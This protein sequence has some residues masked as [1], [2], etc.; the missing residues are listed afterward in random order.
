M[1]KLKVVTR[2]VFG[3]IALGLLLFLTN[4]S[5][6]VGLSYIRHSA[7]SVI[8]V[9]MPLQQQMTQV[10]TQL[11]YLGKLSLR[12]YYLDSLPELT[13]SYQ[14]FIALQQTYRTELQ[15]LTDMVNEPLAV[16]HLKRG[17]DAS[18]AYFMAVE[19][20]YELQKRQHQSAT[21]IA[22]L[23][24]HNITQAND[25]T[26]LL[27][28]IE[29]LENGD[30]DPALQKLVGQ[31]NNIDI[32]LG[33][34]LDNFEDL[35]SIDPTEDNGQFI[36]ELT[37]AFSNLEQAIVF[38]KRSAQDVDT[39]GLILAFDEQWQIV[40]EGLMGDNG[41]L[42]KN[43]IR[44]SEAQQALQ[45]LMDAEAHL[46]TAN[47]ELNI[48]YGIISKQT[49]AGQRDIIAEVENNSTI[50]MLSMLLAVGAVV[51]VA[52]IVTRIIQQPLRLIS[53]S[54]EVI[55]SGDLTHKAN[56]ESHCEFGDLATQLNA[57]SSSLQGLIAQIRREQDH[58][59]S[60]S[61]E[62]A[63][64]GRKTIAQVDKQLL[65]VTK[66]ADNTR[67]VRDFSKSNV[68]QINYG[69]SKL[70]DV[71]KKTSNA[72]HAVSETRE[73]ILTQAQ[74]AQESGKIIKRLNDNSHNIGGI[75]DV[76]KN[77]AEQTNLLALNAAIEAARAGDQGRGFAVVADEVRTLANR[78]QNS[79]AEI[80]TMIASLQDDARLAVKAIDTGQIQAQHNVELIENVNSD[81]DQI[82]TIIKDLAGLNEKIV[83]DADHQDELLKEMNERLETIVELAKRS[84][85]TTH[86][87]NNAVNQMNERMDSLREA[88]AR[89]NI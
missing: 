51:V 43:R 69:T 16:Q 48:L 77:I 46:N 79:T 60:A 87:S 53:R 62:S 86:E 37:F 82:T 76:I 75:L 21:D 13:E 20:M 50:S 25:A 22:Q 85:S 71:V 56:N 54:I 6:F 67:K 2:I 55:S 78:T 17:S 23:T 61:H 44:F 29:F 84:T 64:L 34:V 12:D 65:E 41:L 36:E 15:T 40:S 9:K 81:V 32:Q 89:F 7:E 59:L 11:L 18:K 68:S 38:L 4:I 63:D 24:E 30:T 66:T 5:S 45:Y 8:N 70:N 33:V 28:D 80:E 27:F 47:T 42:N 57:L 10:Q 52:F 14:K 26:A 49:L 39:D 1:F 31:G 58:L 19:K 72:R 83:A 74:Q 73:Q 35:Q 3:F 88:I